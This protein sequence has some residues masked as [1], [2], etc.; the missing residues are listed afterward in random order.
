MRF[1]FDDWV[2]IEGYIFIIMLTSCWLQK[3]CQGVSMKNWPID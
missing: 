2:Y 3:K 1:M